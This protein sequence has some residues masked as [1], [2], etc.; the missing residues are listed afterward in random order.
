L[1]QINQVLGGEGLPAQIAAN[2]SVPTEV[3]ARPAKRRGRK[4]KAANQM[5]LREAVLKALSQ[6]PLARKDMVK[7]VEAEGFPLRIGSVFASKLRHGFPEHSSPLTTRFT[8]LD[9]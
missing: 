6:G 4:P 9:S 2:A 7:A 5:S 3:P 1:N 8:S